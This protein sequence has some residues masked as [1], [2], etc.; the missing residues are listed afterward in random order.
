[1]PVTLTTAEL[2]AANRIGDS[3]EELAEVERLRSY[4]IAELK[5]Y[6]GAAYGTAPDAIVNEAAR[7][8]VGYIFD[9]PLA[10]RGAAYA[11]AVR[12]SGAGR[13]L[14]GYRVHRAGS[15]GDAVA[16]A[17]E[18]VGTPGNPVV[19]VEVEAGAIVVSFADGS[20]RTEALPAG[21]DTP[22]GPAVDQ[23]AR[24]A[25]Q[26]AQAAADAAQATADEK[27]DQLMPPSTAEA[28]NATATTI[29]GW[30]AALL[31]VLVEAIVPAW[32]R[33]NATPVPLAK[34]A[35]LIDGH[36]AVV[37]VR[38]GRLPGPPVAVRLGWSQ[39]RTMSAAVFTRAGQHPIDGAEVGTSSG[40]TVPPFPPALDTDPTL[41]LG[42]WTPGD[43]DVEEIAGGIGFAGKAPLTVNGVAGHYRTS[44]LRL[45]A[46]VVG[47]TIR[48]VTGGARI[49]TENDLA[50]LGG[51]PTVLGEYAFSVNNG[52]FVSTGIT[53]PSDRPAL[54]VSARDFEWDHDTQAI[55]RTYERTAT[56]LVD[57]AELGTA[58]ARAAGDPAVTNPA[59][60][61]DDHRGCVIRLG[62]FEVQAAMTAGRVLLLGFPAGA[63][64]SV[65]SGTLVVKA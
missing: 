28:E 22:D 8:I 5:R 42:L 30:T 19:N 14:L 61:T 23:T 52:N 11:N 10:S 29:R 17:Q 21:S 4:A 7:A 46:T 24:D 15:T 36:G 63:A 6:L 62:N 51:P 58:T 60:R 45:P 57:I 16:A 33:D 27:Q 20:T 38:D 55:D 12:N 1:M 53:V 64:N 39:S 18:A 25:A 41:Y 50:G 40:V 32:A 43:P 56:A 13:M 2:A 37:N 59:D 65:L 31:R 9:A 47:T 48:L 44:S 35:G 34:V 49:L 3:T 26:A 54:H